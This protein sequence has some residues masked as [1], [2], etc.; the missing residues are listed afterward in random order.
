MTKLPIREMKE[1]LYECRYVTPWKDIVEGEEYHIP[2]I[3]SL[4]RRDLHITKK[5]ETH[6]EYYKI[7]DKEK[8]IRSIQYDSVFSRLLVKKK[9]F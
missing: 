4:L 2:P 7:G 8:N 6:L 9:N 1:K 5:D 3:L